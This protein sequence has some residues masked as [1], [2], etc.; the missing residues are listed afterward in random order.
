[1]SN[2][3]RAWARV[4]AHH[5]F[6]SEYAKAFRVL[7]RFPIYTLK[8]AS[9]H[10]ILNGDIFDVEKHTTA[11]GHPKDQVDRGDDFMDAKRYQDAERLNELVELQ[12]KMQAE[13]GAEG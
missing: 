9:R 2:V 13:M 8:G 1:M 10:H 5:R 11:G 3:A 6:R 12:R 4:A 7:A